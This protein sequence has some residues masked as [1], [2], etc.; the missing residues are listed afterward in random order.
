MNLHFQYPLSPLPSPPP[1]SSSH[2]PSN[3]YG[4][5]LD[6]LR[7]LTEGSK[8]Q[9]PTTLVRNKDL[10]LVSLGNFT[11]SSDRNVMLLRVD[12]TSSAPPS[13]NIRRRQWKL[14]MWKVASM[15]MHV[16]REGVRGRAQL[17]RPK[18]HFQSPAISGHIGIGISRPPLSAPPS[19]RRPCLEMSAKG[20]IG[21]SPLKMSSCIWFFD[22]E[23]FCILPYPSSRCFVPFCPDDPL[24]RYL[25]PL[26]RDEPRGAESGRRT[27][28]SRQ[29]M[30]R[31][32]A[33]APRTRTPIL[34]I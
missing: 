30:I 11:P 1:T 34:G 6:S 10:H 28:S 2:H 5:R 23:S 17:T 3:K 31:Q 8:F 29:T 21:S 26:G 14:E 25:L 9:V 19:P 18:T 7:A 4:S 27:D 20:L 22:D 15:R 12:P 16:R 32:T 24:S 13:S 33:A